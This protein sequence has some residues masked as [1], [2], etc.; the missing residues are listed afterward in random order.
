MATIKC[1]QKLSKM[2]G[3]SLE[4]PE[5]DSG[6]DW[7]ANI[8]VID[9][10]RYVLFCSDSTRLCCLA[11]PVRKKD[12]QN[13]PQLLAGAL[14]ATMKYEGFDEASISYCLDKLEGATLSKTNSKSILG[15]INDNVWHL[16]VHASHAGGV[17]AIGTEAL[18]EKVNHMPLNP[19]NW[20]YAISEFRKY[21]IRA[22]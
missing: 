10:L 9:R 18:V 7:H 17:A 13:L 12:V 15:T 3:V 2:M 4:P 14:V 11:G 22:V 16:E 21:A 8:F 1:T 6:D 19:L 5:T 20:S